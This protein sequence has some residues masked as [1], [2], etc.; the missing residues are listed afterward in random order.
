MNR[1]LLFLLTRSL[2]NAVVSRI[3]R[4]RQPKYLI[5]TLIGAAYFYFYFFRVLFGGGFNRE[6]KGFEPIR[7]LD[8]DS[9][10]QL[11]A[12]VLLAVFIVFAWIIP[13]SRAALTFT[14]AELA[15]LL[16]APIS[17]A[18]LI[19]YK[20]LKSQLGLLLLAVFMTLL[21]GRVARDGLAVVHT[22]GWWVVF[23]TLQLHRLGASFVLK[24][25]LDRGLSTWRRRLLVLVMALAFVGLLLIWRQAAP[26][27]PALDQL[28]TPGAWLSFLH[29]L[30]TT[31]PAP[32]L[33]A[34]FRIV[35]RP[36]FAANGW[37][38][39]VTLLPALGLM[40]L[41]YLWI[42]RLDVAFEEA[43]IEL[44]QKRAA[45]LAARRSGN[46]RST[47][48]VRKREPL[49]R[50]RPRGW[51]FVAFIWKSFI[52]AGGR[53][54][55]RRG[56][57]IFAVAAVLGW[58]L[59]N[60]PTYGPLVHLLAML[61]ATVV[62]MVSLFVGP[63]AT[64]QSVR[65]ELMISDW[66]KTVPVPNSQMV[67]GLLLGPALIVTALQT[68]S[69]V[70][71]YSDAAMLAEMTVFGWI[72][73]VIVPALLALPALNIVLSL[74]PTGIMIFFAGWFR[75]GEQRGLEATGLGLIMM[76]AQLALVVVALIP[77]ALAVAGVAFG[78]QFIF[79]SPLA[80][81][82]A[83]LAGTTTLSIE[84]WLGVLL[85]AQILARYDPSLE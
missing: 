5:G 12:L 7:A 54:I 37:D 56:V 11:A 33:L 66:L 63:Q 64:A 68:A 60:N 75:P 59:R 50:L 70:L 10:V 24:R 79:A 71:A 2:A 25:A 28:R 17:R 35:V 84:A 38:F 32:W 20:L 30:A 57:I 51:A 40:A 82:I 42:T 47:V 3:N 77:T 34:P 29:E 69:I 18:T 76:V 14:E 49:F 26:A 22:L 39:L 78:L 83:G 13:A 55:A 74:I 43:S 4:L 15:F 61:A 6:P 80:F 21:T 72:P 8:H 45:W 81:A 41:H 19:H 27:A 23:A 1:A 53:H 62:F 48:S 85:L 52:Q 67:L 44:S 65:R 16:P 58:S 36:Y 31:G 9:M 46:I 73:F